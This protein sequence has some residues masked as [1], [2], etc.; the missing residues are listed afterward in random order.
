MHISSEQNR[1][2]PSSQ[3][4]SAVI[5]SQCFLPE[6]RDSVN[7]QVHKFPV[8][9]STKQQAPR[10]EDL[11]SK[12]V[13]QMSD[14]TKPNP[15]DDRRARKGMCCMR[16]LHQTITPSPPSDNPGCFPGN[17]LRTQVSQAAQVCGKLQIRK[18]GRKEV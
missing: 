6:L 15:G 14:K 12:I 5:R 9:T 17:G 18:C 1:I 16:N 2:R 3:P 10:G 4:L 13:A 8:V 7:F 11:F